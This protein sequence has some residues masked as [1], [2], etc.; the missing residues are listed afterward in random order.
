MEPDVCDYLT[1]LHAAG[2]IRDVVVAPI[3]FVSDHMEVLFDL[4]TEARELCNE[5]GLNMV[6]AMTVGTH[7]KFIRMIRELILERTTGTERRALGGFGP[8]HDA[9]AAD[10]CPSAR[11][12]SR[13]EDQ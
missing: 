11:R 7:P 6:R 10:C 5:L 8:S 3:G 12:A 13:A 2:N 4:D 1:E 9:C